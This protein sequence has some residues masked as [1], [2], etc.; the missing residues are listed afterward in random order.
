MTDVKHWPV[1][2]RPARWVTINGERHPA[3]EHA[4]HGTRRLVAWGANYQWVPDTQ[5]TDRTD[6]ET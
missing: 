5:V 1:L 6:D 4:Q 2:D 3:R